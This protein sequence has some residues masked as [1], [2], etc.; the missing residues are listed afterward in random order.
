[1]SIQ[2]MAA[3]MRVEIDDIEKTRWQDTQLAVFLTKSA[4][5]I[6]QLAIRHELDFAMKA[7]DVILKTDGSIEGIVYD[8]VN[9]VCMLTRKDNKIPLKHLLP[10]HYLTADSVSGVAIWTFLN[11]IAQYREPASEDVPAVFLHYPIVTI[12][13]TE[14]PWNGRLDDLIVEYASLRA[15]NVDEM[16]LQMDMQLMGELEKR[17]LEN[18][19]RIQP[20]I[21]K[22]RGW[23]TG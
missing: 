5:R 18:Y 21:S 16:T 6:N 11:G 20:Q 22:M 2:T 14:S 1:M 3:Q 7:D 8:K 19:N 4:R 13:S 17:L 10:M 12:S 9:A 23:N 15:K